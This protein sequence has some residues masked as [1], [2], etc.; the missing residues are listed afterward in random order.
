MRT[1]TI[2]VTGPLTKRS[3]QVRCIER[4]DIVQAFTT[5]RAD[6]PFAMGVGGGHSDWC[7]QDL[8]APAFYFLVEAA[9][10]SLVSIMK[11]KLVILIAGKHLSQ[12]LQSAIRIWVFG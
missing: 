2:V 1:A 4:N 11:Q 7:S 6:Q 10:E 9:R 8:D 3:S 5:D 12:P